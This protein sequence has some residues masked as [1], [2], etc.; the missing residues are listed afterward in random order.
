MT[1]EVKDL[2]KSI[3]ALRLEVDESIVT[4]ILEKATKAIESTII[5]PDIISPIYDKVAD[6]T[7]ADRSRIVAAESNGRLSFYELDLFEEKVVRFLTM[8]KI[9]NDG[10]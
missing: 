10:R 7:K 8:I 4:S 1:T 2:F 6:D 5:N 9:S 3:N